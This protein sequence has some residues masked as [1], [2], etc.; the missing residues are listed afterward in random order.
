MKSVRDV[1]VDLGLAPDIAPIA[2]TP[3]K[4]LFEGPKPNGK[5][6]AVCQRLFG[7]PA[8]YVTCRL[9]SA[10]VCRR[11]GT[12]KGVHHAAHRV[13]AKKARKQGIA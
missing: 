9:C 12:C 13:A 7:N 3:T 11:R 6:C 2:H 4:H 8:E 10:A 1:A 5:Q